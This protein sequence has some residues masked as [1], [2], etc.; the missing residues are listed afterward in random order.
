MQYG[1]FGS[2]NRVLL[3]DNQYMI[4]KD[5][6]AAVDACRKLREEHGVFVEVKPIKLDFT[7]IKG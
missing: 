4:F 5:I 3:E 7:F 1:L 6:E 2:G